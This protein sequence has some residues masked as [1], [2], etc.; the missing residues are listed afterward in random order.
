MY[1]LIEDD[2]LLE[3]HNTVWGIVSAGIKKNLITTLSAIKS[4]LKLKWFLR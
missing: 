3:K 4:F 1:F 2:D